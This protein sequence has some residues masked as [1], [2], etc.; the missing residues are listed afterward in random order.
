MDRDLN[1][2]SLPVFRR[3]FLIA[4]VVALI[5]GVALAP[6]LIEGLARRHLSRCM[7]NL[8]NIAI[9]LEIYSAD[10]DGRYPRNLDALVPTYLESIPEC[11]AAGRISYRADFGPSAVR[12]GGQFLD[13][14]C[15][16]CTGGNHQGLSVSPDYPK[17][18][19]IDGL[20]DR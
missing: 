20:V 18:C 7:C 5:I 17:F 14:Y 8:K 4:V 6:K 10:H 15:V 3:R 13:Y 19:G 2:H 11:P 16:E 1:D 9:T 12:N